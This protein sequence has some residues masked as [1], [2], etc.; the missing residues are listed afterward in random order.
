MDMDN[1]FRSARLVYVGVEDNDE[2]RAFL[3]DKIT[4]DPVSQAQTV[5][6]CVPAT[7]KSA[8][9]LAKYMVN[10]AGLAVLICLP[11]ELD[12]AGGSKPTPIGFVNL[13][14][15]RKAVPWLRRT[16]IGIAIAREHQGKGYGSEAI[17]W[18]ADWA[19]T[20]GGM[21]KVSIGAM[22]YNPGAVRLYKR[23]GFVEEGRI[24]HDVWFNG[25]WFDRVELGMLED[26]WRELRGR[27]QESK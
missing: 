5:G 3:F 23:L 10:D 1:A 2:H 27:K 11:P 17:E 21:H 12:Q 20:F 8:D 6:G 13:H 24:R 26:E 19:F 16:S 25:E 4:S 18:V 7:K 9:E 15:A 22:S 14:H